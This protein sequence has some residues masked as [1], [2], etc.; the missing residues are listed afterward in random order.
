MGDTAIAAASADIFPIAA[1]L[2]I[3]I[4]APSSPIISFRVLSATPFW[5]ELV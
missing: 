4:L 5:A 3:E 1:T 2:G